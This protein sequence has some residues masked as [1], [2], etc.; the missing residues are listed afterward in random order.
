MENLKIEVKG[1]G[2]LITVPNLKAKGK[3]SKSGKTKIVAGT[4]GFIAVDHP[5]GAKV[6]VN[7]TV[8][9]DDE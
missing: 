1:D 3:I 7:V 2:L 4:G 6:S 9:S 5:S 8:P